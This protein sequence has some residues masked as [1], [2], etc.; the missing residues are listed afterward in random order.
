MN[1]E[2]FR[3]LLQRY[4]DNTC[5]PQERQIVDYWFESYQLDQTQTSTNWN[6]LEERLWN[7]IQEKIDFE[8]PK[9]SV[10]RLWQKPFFRYGMVAS[11][12]VLV[13]VVY[14]LFFMQNSDNQYFSEIPAKIIKEENSSKM[15]KIIRLTDGSRVIL[16]PN[17]KL[18]FPAVFGAKTREVKLIGEAF[19]EIKSD[20][21]KPFLVI[22]NEVITKVLGTSFYVKAQQSSKV[23][24]EV[25]TGKV[26]VF[27][28]KAKDL[29]NN[30]VI[31]LPNHKVTYYAEGKHFVT[32]IISEPKVIKPFVEKTDFLLKNV[33][34][35]D[36]ITKLETVYGIEIL[37]ENENLGNCTIT[38]DLSEMEMFTQLD[39]I[40]HTLGATYQI[41]GT[42]IL[43]LGNGCQ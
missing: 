37:L 41:K 9:T 32:G 24:V 16:S 23:E 18:V 1:R 42:N 3:A 6:E 31:L 13:G 19:F 5:L 12:L 29:P 7:K 27:E 38:G 2:A 43:I 33:P 25:R 28:R 10:V 14:G 4:L 8:N 15:N 35:K 30:G 20:P 17:A 39:I 21:K 22:T 26:T 40:S 36:V 34:L 11:L